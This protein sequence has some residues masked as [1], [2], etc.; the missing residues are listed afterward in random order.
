MQLKKF[1]NWCCASL[2]GHVVL[3]QLCFSL[4]LLLFFLPTI[5][6]QGTLT[7]AWVLYMFFALM[8]L[9]AVCAV[10]FWYTIT[11]PLLNNRRGK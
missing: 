11:L 8:T 5:Y 1:F 4:P 6:S 10:L 7:V 3:M 2:L 9:G